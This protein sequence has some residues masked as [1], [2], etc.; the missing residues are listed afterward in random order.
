MCSPEEL[1]QF[2][3]FRGLR[4]PYPSGLTLK[5]MYVKIL[6]EADR[7]ATFR[8]LDLPAEMRNL[9]YAELLTFNVDTCPGHRFCYAQILRTCKAVNQE[10]ISILY[11][12][13]VFDARFTVIA[14]DE[15]PAAMVT[16]AMIHKQ[17][18]RV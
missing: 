18:V 6:D 10:A 2:V 3:K 14:A 5:A 4:D 15:V 9:V 12:D 17:A 13:N 11:E 16:D 8:F 7:E 1:K